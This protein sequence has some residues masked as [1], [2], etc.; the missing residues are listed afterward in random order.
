[1]KK[2]II[3]LND[4]SSTLNIFFQILPY[5]RNLI[6]RFRTVSTLPEQMSNSTR[7]LSSMYQKTSYKTSYPTNNLSINNGY[8]ILLL[9]FK[10][11]S[12]GS[13]HVAQC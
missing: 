4:F 3:N 13:I 9:L 6:L 2:V 11:G 5:L 7:W 8:L 12:A 1:M 10:Q